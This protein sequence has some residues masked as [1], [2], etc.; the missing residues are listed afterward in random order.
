MMSE[1][2]GEGTFHA[3]VEHMPGLWNSGH[4]YGKRQGSQQECMLRGGA[5]VGR[6]YLLH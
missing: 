4:V 2:E 5:S 1:R 6:A 3:D